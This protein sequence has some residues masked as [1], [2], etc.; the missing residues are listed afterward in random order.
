MCTIGNEIIEKCHRQRKNLGKIYN[1]LVNT[2][3]L[4]VKSAI[5]CKR[6]LE[7]ALRTDEGSIVGNMRFIDIFMNIYAYQIQYAQCARF[8]MRI[9]REAKKTKT[10]KIR[11]T[12]CIVNDVHSLHK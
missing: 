11:R 6:V 3:S 9:K 10:Q 8:E 12:A 5:D 2:N 4:A 7:W 1:Q